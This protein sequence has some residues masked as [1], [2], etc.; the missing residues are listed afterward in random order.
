M[1]L[2]KLKILGIIIAF[3]SCFLLHYLYELLPCFV[4]S[5]FAP[6][7]ESIFEHMK[8]IFSSILLSGVIQ[9]IRLA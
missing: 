1:S 3:L 6:V 5:I 7:N 4:V 2:K 8:I 9:K